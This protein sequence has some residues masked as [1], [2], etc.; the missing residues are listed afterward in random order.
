MTRFHPEIVT[1]PPYIKDIDLQHDTNGH[2]VG[3]IARPQQ[4]TYHATCTQDI[5]TQL[6]STPTSYRASQRPKTATTEKIRCR[7]TASRVATPPEGPLKH[8]PTH[9]SD[10]RRSE[11]PNKEGQKC[12]Q[13]RKASSRPSEAASSDSDVPLLKRR[14]T[15]PN[16]A[17]K[18]E[19]LEGKIKRL[20]EEMDDFKERE[21]SL[22]KEIEQ[23]MNMN[24]ELKMRARNVANELGVVRKW[25]TERGVWETAPECVK[26]VIRMDR[27]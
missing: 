20:N 13:R 11:T 8:V 15:N 26:R 7:N 9:K 19:E 12:P 22:T 10:T 4:N 18:V 21:D 25:M 27:F 1:K 23:A 3:K 17:E 2:W 5:I 16:Q 6:R 14:R 24:W